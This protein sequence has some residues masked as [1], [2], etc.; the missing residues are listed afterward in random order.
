MSREILSLK[1]RED[2]TFEF[3][4]DGEFAEEWKVKEFDDSVW[5]WMVVKIL[6]HLRNIADKRLKLLEDKDWYSRQ[7]TKGRKVLR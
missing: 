2:G 3:Y 4:E 5:G 1:R 7:P 6:R